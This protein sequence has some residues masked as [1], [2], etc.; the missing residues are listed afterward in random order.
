MSLSIKLQILLI[1]GFCLLP[2]HSFQPALADSEVLQ[3]GVQQNDTI[4]RLARPNG[5]QGTGQ[6]DS[7][8]LG[9]PLAG[10]ANAASPLSGMV[11][12][13]QFSKPFN[14]QAQAA[15]LGLVHPDQFSNLSADKFDLGA[16]R[17]SKEL[18]IGW[19][20]WYK[21]LSAAIYNRWSQVAAVSGHAVVRLTVTRD[22]IL[23][24]VMVQSSGNPDFDSGLIQAILSLNGNQGLAFPSGSQRKAV[25][26]ESDYIAGSNID[27]GY[28]WIRGDVEKINQSY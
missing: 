2:V 9:R 5:I 27:P 24:A 16:D 8:R 10:S 18:L 28:S 17:G 14:G 12:T 19:E 25:A 20:R 13:S 11:D 4:T 7:L 15:G 26:L 23:N 6:T 1:A 22:R 21:Q 3:G